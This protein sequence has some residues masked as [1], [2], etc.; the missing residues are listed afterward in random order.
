MNV[1]VVAVF[2]S[3]AVCVGYICVYVVAGVG[4]V[5]GCVCRGVADVCWCSWFR[6]WCCYDGY[7]FSYTR[8][9]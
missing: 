5:A 2:A 1:V 9:C 8:W 3:I 4:S 6:Y 7:A